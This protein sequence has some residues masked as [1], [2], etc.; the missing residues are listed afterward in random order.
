MENNNN[1]RKRE[2]KSIN[3][4]YEI[5]KYYNDLVKKNVENAKSKTVDNFKLKQISTLNTILSKANQI[6]ESYTENQCTEK[7]MRF[8]KSVYGDVDEELYEYFL[9][10]R[11][12]NAEICTNDLKSKSLE[13]AIGKNYTDFK[14][15]NGYI[16]CFKSR[17]NIQFKDLRG[18]AGS[19]DTSITNDWFNKIKT[20]LKDYASEDI[21]NL[22]ETGLFYRAQKGRTFV[23]GKESNDKNLRGMKKSKDRLTVLVGASMSGEKLPLLVIGKSLSPYCLRR[24]S[25][26]DNTFYRSQPSAWMDANIFKEYLTKLDTRFQSC[27]RNCIIFIDNCRAHP[28]VTSLQNLKR[29]KVYFFPP[30]ITSVCQPMDMGIIANLK[31][32]YKNYLSNDKNKCLEH[33]THFS[34]NILDAMLNLKKSWDDVKPTM[35]QNC[36]KKAQFIKDSTLSNVDIIEIEKL[37]DELPTFEDDHLPICDM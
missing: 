9:K 11:K 36:F 6:N 3:E 25:V 34:V 4:K 37:Q 14:A 33:D 30:N 29:I 10:M 18:E 32:N 2:S 35:I 7:R 19:V 8:T 13:I 26:P 16:R 20:I 23:T 28:P 24:S 31:L 15:S 5:I 12:K 17:Y 21:Y 27:N 1:K 22:D